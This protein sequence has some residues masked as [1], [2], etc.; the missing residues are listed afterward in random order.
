MQ[1]SQS[2]SKHDTVFAYLPGQFLNLM[3]SYI[4]DTIAVGDWKPNQAAI[5]LPGG[6]VGVGVASFLISL[7]SEWSFWIT[8]PFQIREDINSL[9][10]SMCS[11]QRSPKSLGHLV[12]T[13]K[14]CFHSA[15]GLPWHTLSTCLRYPWPSK[16][17]V[18]ISNLFLTNFSRIG[19]QLGTT[20]DKTQLPR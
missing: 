16:F 1:F 5:L 11:H 7:C 8:L 4:V 9:V 6:S 10:F 13:K 12:C 20:V 17:F 3:Y 15:P 14:L 2:N 18:E 19:A